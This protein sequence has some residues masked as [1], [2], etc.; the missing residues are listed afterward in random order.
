MVSLSYIYERGEGVPVSD[1]LAEEWRNRAEQAVDE[2]QDGLVVRAD[3]ADQM[4]VQ[5]AHLAAFSLLGKMYLEGV[6]VEKDPERARQLVEQAAELGNV[7]AQYLLAVMIESGRLGEPDYQKA[8]EWISRAAEAE[9]ADAQA[10]LGER[11]L[12]GRF[13]PQDYERAAFWLNSAAK[14]G[15]ARGLFSLGAI[16]EYG[17]GVERDRGAAIDC[18]MKASA[19]GYLAAKSHL[20]AF[21]MNPEEKSS[22]D[23]ALAI[24]LMKEAAAEG[25]AEAQYNLGACYESGQGV[26]EDR[27]AAMGWFE[28][29]AG[30]GLP[31]AQFTL[32]TMLAS[33]GALVPAFVWFTI[34]KMMLERSGSDEAKEMVEESLE[35]IRSR[36]SADEIEE[37]ERALKA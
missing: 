18:Y 27:A 37:A 3:D 31:I 21:L 2:V 29:A 4:S 10:N 25:H 9:N 22:D 26:G 34:Y 30:Q 17:L 1:L 24:E 12:Q 14:Q 32:A 13:R 36:M 7:E 6:V 11:Y 23:E 20:A 35:D 28:K 15:S 16:Y 33:D 8:D 19:K 5:R